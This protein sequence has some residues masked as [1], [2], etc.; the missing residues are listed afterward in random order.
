MLGQRESIQEFQGKLPFFFYAIA[1]ALSLLAFRLL[2]LQVYRGSSYREFSTENS[3]RR[4]KIPGP[5][6]QILDRDNRVLVDNRLQLDVIITPQ[7]AKDVVG[8]IQVL[9]KLA[10]EA[11]DVL[12][13]RYEEK[14]RVS[15]RFQSVTIIADAP[16][17][18][19]VKVE[20]NKVKFP[21]L[22]IE[23]RIRRTYMQKQVG[24]HLYGYLSEVT[25]KELERNTQLGKSYEQGDWIGRFGLERQWERYL[26]GVDG[27]RLVVVD[28]H[29][30]RLSNSISEVSVLRKMEKEVQPQTGN[31][32][33]LTVDADLQKAA[34]DGFAG[35]M[36]AVVAMDPRTGEI[37]A[38]VSQPSFDPTEM[39]QKGPDLWAS[40]VN[41]PYGPLRNKSIQDHFPPGSTFK[42]FTAL[43]AL[44]NGIIN[45]KQTVFCPGSFRFGNRTYYCHKKDGHG[46]VD[47][48]SALRGSCDV[49]FWTLASRLNVDAISKVAG[50]FG[51]GRKTQIELANETS[52]L[53]PT[54]E[55]KRKAYN[56]PWT[57]GE[58]LSVA[59]GQGADLVTPLQ[60]AVSYSALINGGNVYKPYVVS[61]IEDYKGK[62]IKTMGPELMSNY[63]VNPEYL[64][65]IK[66]ALFEVVNA[67]GGTATRHAKS[68]EV[69]IS[70]KSGTSQVVSLSKD[71]LYAPCV[72]LPFE[73][74]HHAWFVGYAPREKPEIVVSV[75]GMHECGGSI[76]SSPV[77][78]NIIETWWRKKK[79]SSEVFGPQQPAAR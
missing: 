14:R 25:K 66:Q 38:M 29:G 56:Q 74:R 42:V 12:M 53:M 44:E 20:S 46:A 57:P 47:L 2:Y 65:T 43:A 18:L 67:A 73:R 68:M 8:T 55:W 64:E 72:N 10:D 1:I 21:G 58:T 37:L 28:A 7:F 41:N 30:H 26:R 9:A 6:G 79:A 27:A 52:G 35:K 54:E 19:V 45:H 16:W 32:L 50:Y 17:D 33:I 69:E 51:L 70:G 39:A 3:I 23:P 71:E 13:K 78:K 4:E 48:I 40:F 24:A 63:K 62:V 34:A 36:G 15:A 59:I 49:Y 31:N 11:P 77:V 75:F 60:L 76:S 5:R 61:K 22:E